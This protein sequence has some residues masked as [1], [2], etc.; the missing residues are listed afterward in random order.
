MRRLLIIAALALMALPAAPAGADEITVTGPPLTINDDA[1]ATPYPSTLE[2]TDLDGAITNVTAGL[3]GVKHDAPNDIDALLV[4]PGGRNVVIFSDACQSEIWESVEIFFDDSAPTLA[5]FDPP[6]SAE[7][8]CE[9]SFFKPTNHPP[10]ADGF[11]APAPNPPYGSTL[12]VFNGSSPAGSWRLFAVDDTAFG[13]GVVQSWTLTLDGV[14]SSLRCAGKRATIVGTDVRNEIKGTK[15][16]DVIVAL[17]GNDRVRGRGGSDRICG[18]AGKD[19]L[20]GGGGNDRLF[21]GAGKDL[22]VGGKGRD[23]L[24]GGGGKDK[25]KQ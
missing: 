17:G 25:E 11:P 22:L 18:G 3:V 15:R 16:A 9:P 4:G 1:P 13:S 2:V 24:K 23:R 12:S 14:R 7:T 21:G 5:P 8:S 10:T 20:L 19:R 6:V